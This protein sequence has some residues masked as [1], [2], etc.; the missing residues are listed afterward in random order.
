M[1]KKSS[2]QAQRKNKIS[3]R[4]TNNQMQILGEL[5]DR[6]GCSYSTMIR[7]MVL[8]FLTVYEHEL[9]EIITGRRMITEEEIRYINSNDYGEEL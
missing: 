1:T 4:L 6:L 8:N 9:E 2:A 5:K 7:S 3:V